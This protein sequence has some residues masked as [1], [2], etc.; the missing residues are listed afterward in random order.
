[1]V[2]GSETSTNSNEVRQN[3]TNLFGSF[4][5]KLLYIRLAV[6]PMQIA[7]SFYAP[8]AISPWPWRK[9]DRGDWINSRAINQLKISMRVN[10]S[11]GRPTR[12]IYF[13]YMPTMM[14]M[15]MMMT[16]VLM[17][18]IPLLFVSLFA[19]VFMAPKGSC[20]YLWIELIN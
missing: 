5:Y 2:D 16:I 7:P 3:M 12:A 18:M 13:C 19:L 15:K 11:W 17:M 20:K 8:A 6:P 9:C 1:M 4:I 10:S 14:T